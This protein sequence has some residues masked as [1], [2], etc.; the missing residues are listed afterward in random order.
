MKGQRRTLLSPSEKC[1]DSSEA[2]SSIRL[3]TL[4]QVRSFWCVCC[5]P[6]RGTGRLSKACGRM[7]LHSGRGSS[8]VDL[9][10]SS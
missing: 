5:C 7:Q 4:R 1:I 8:A 6:L 2:R 9:K 3:G 10:R